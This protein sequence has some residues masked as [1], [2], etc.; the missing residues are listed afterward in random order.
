[1]SIFVSNIFKACYVYLIA[2]AITQTNKGR[3]GDQVVSVLAIN[4]NDPSSSPAEV[5]N[6]CCKELKLTKAI[7]KKN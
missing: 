5:Y 6:C 4:S 3:D 2:E 7:L 1:M